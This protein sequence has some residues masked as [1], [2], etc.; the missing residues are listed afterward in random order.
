MN[1]NQP[2]QDIL[3][4]VH[5]GSA[6]GSA[7]FNNGYKSA[8]ASRRELIDALN[9]WDGGVLVIDGDLSDELP[10]YPMFNRAI[11][12]ALARAQEHGHISRRVMGNDPDQVDRSREFV[13]SLP[14]QGKSMRFEVTGAWY[15]PEDGMGCVGSVINELKKMNCQ[16][17]LGD[18]AVR[19]LDDIPGDGL[20]V[21]PSLMR[22]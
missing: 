7:N 15:H 1:E 22:P 21:M 2:L 6:C 12:S 13:A 10:D 8:E 11:E 19:P 5:P 4:L 3:I 17:Y 16:V 14:D 9:Q 18:S 20:L